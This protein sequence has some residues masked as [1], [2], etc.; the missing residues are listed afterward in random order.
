VWRLGAAMFMT[1]RGL[2]RLPAWLFG[3]AAIRGTAAVLAVAPAQI[4]PLPA[5][6]NGQPPLRGRDAVR[7][8]AGKFRAAFPD[9]N[10]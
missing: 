2:R 9:L 4:F 7:V 8:F 10:F 5:P 3:F 1:D 6:A